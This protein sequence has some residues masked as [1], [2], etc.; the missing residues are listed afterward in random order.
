MCTC[1]CVFDSLFTKWDRELC[2]RVCVFLIVYSLNGIGSCVHV[3]VC[4]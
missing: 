1:L 4:F 3:F 2:A